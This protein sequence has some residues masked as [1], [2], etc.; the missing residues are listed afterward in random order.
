MSKKDNGYSNEVTKKTLSLDSAD[1]MK[2]INAPAPS[3]S[4]GEV[5]GSEVNK[6]MASATAQA[7]P[8]KT[9]GKVNK[10]VLST[11]EGGGYGDFGC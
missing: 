5:D 11:S 1:K 9:K 6:A 8:S 4:K 3:N 10:S 2:G 7:T